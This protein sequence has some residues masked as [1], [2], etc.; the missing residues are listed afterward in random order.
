[1]LYSTA[2]VV[3]VVPP[4]VVALSKAY[5]AAD[6]DVLQLCW[7]HGGYNEAGSRSFLVPQLLPR[8]LSSL[9]SF[10][11]HSQPLLCL[12]NLYVPRCLLLPVH[13]LDHETSTLR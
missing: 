11:S 10:P 9:N 1:M 13:L 7:K 3:A 5:F 6:K 12:R 8:E 4:G 2:A